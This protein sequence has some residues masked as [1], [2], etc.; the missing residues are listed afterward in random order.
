LV[1]ALKRALTSCFLL[2]VFLSANISNADY[3]TSYSINLMG[4][5]WPRRDIPVYVSGNVEQAHRDAVLLAVRIWIAAQ[6]WFSETYMASEG[7]PFFLYLSDKPLES[8]ITI[9][10]VV[11]A[12]KVLGGDTQVSIRNGI[13]I[14]VSI[15]VNL[16]STSILPGDP[17]VQ[18]VLLHEL[19][20]A[21]GLGHTQAEYDLMY[22]ATRAR[23]PTIPL[24]STLDLYA[25]FLLGQGKLEAPVRLPS[26][27]SYASPPW[28]VQGTLKV[29]PYYGESRYK[30]A[31]SY[32]KPAIVGSNLRLGIRIDNIGKK[33]V[34]VINTTVVC[35]WN[36]GSP[37]KS[38]NVTDVV[39]PGSDLSFAW[40][41]P[42]PSNVSLGN[43]AFVFRTWT[44]TLQADG[45]TFL[46]PKLS[47][48]TVT[49]PVVRATGT[50]AL[51][52]TP[53][54]PTSEMTA[55]YVLLGLVV[56]VVVVAAVAVSTRS[57]R[58]GK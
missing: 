53:A 13:P 45:W 51:T 15:Y 30:F 33:P 5:A 37:V 40:Q 42:V 2:A 54:A 46:M 32:S 25:L 39:Q 31:Y 10:F 8:A 38:T 55:T 28:I 57:R 34:K 20:H 3:Q 9:S 27:I 6:G 22:G 14:K 18:S 23:P 4:F 1:L 49:V 19:G 36:P 52:T 17:Y 43:H 58:A 11:N 50:Q 35:D 24:P 48:Q 56:V 41:V 26:S 16:P 47:E 12:S 7:Y 44:A 29:P 21:L